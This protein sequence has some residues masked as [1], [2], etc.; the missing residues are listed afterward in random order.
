MR[1]AET[2]P[3]P[4]LTTFVGCIWTLE[5]H[6]SE[7]ASALQPVLPDGRPE[8]VIHFGYTFERVHPDGAAERQAPILFAG[9]MTG[10]LALRPTGR[11]A[12]LGVRIYTSAA[13]ANHT[14]VSGRCSPGGDVWLDEA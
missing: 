13:D 2:A 14:T 5:G 11:M 6:A 4:S 1:Y 10:Q 12:V 3:L 8:L 9:Q 7:L